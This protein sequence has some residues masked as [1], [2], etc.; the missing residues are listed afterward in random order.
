[1]VLYL[2][3]FL[4]IVIAIVITSF[5]FH[6]LRTPQGKAT[7]DA[8]SRPYARNA[9]VFVSCMYVPANLAPAL[10]PP[11]GTPTAD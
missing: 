5:Y 7:P 8:A 11:H 9:P 2:V 4:A 10:D 3:V 1:M 6:S